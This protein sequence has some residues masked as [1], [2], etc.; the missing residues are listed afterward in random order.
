MKIYVTFMHNI[1]VQ[2]DGIHLW[3]DVVSYDELLM[4]ESNNEIIILDA[5]TEAVKTE[6]RDLLGDIIQLT[7]G[8]DE[9]IMDLTLGTE[10][11]NNDADPD[12]E[13]AKNIIDLE[14]EDPEK[15]IIDLKC[16]ETIE[17]AEN[18][19]DLTVGSVLDVNNN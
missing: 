19:I 13:E 3:A 14:Q 1:S 6:E 15:N 2:V 10:R 7:L 8:S 9:E 17:A 5:N 11:N 4:K 16:Y 18:I 12:S